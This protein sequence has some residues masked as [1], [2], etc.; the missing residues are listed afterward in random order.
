VRL[1][2]T[3]VVILAVAYVVDLIRPNTSE[4]ARRPSLQP[5]RAASAARQELESARY[6]ATSADAAALQMPQTASEC[7]ATLRKAGVDYRVLPGKVASGIAWP[8]RLTGP[9]GGVR[10][11]GSGK[12]DAA[13]NFLDC[14]LATTL[15]AW[16][17]TLRAHGVV[18]I[19]H[20]SMYRPQAQVDGT[21][22]P[23]GHA[24]G[25]AIDMGRIELQDGRI[26][27]V[28]DDW[29]SR[30]PNGDPCGRWRD[31]PAGRLLRKLVC[32]A[33][34][35]GLFQTIVTPHHNAAH[36]N[37]VHLEIDPAAGELWIR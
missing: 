23:S 8:I 18:A 12:P 27:S 2:L 31:E 10:V 33:A 26:L 5:S 11:E 20:F 30:T 9:I 34:A 17:K 36:A 32:D 24:S 21:R 16:A 14:G 37:H 6:A 4:G 7:E 1:F 22:K 25:R 29:K 19:E 15:L 13:T 28:L 3:L 35:R